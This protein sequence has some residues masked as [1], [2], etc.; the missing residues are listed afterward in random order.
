MKN[1]YVHLE[2]NSD[3]KFYIYEPAMVSKNS[4]NEY[5]INNHYFKNG[6]IGCDFNNNQYVISYSSEIIEVFKDNIGK[7][8]ISRLIG[9]DLFFVKNIYLE[10]LDNGH[11]IDRLSFEIATLEIEEKIKIF[12]LSEKI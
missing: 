6:I 12:D 3:F 10:E 5:N 9:S 8:I 1:V 7:A 2:K 11:L 4:Y